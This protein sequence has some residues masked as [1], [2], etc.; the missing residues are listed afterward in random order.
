MMDG[1][2]DGEWDGSHK[3][4]FECDPMT[5]DNKIQCVISKFLLLLLF[6]P[7]FNTGSF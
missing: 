3:Q 2:F 4:I 1:G 5:V 7:V 6:K